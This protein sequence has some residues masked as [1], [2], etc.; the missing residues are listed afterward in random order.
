MLRRAGCWCG[1]A[2]GDR[3][4]A[5]AEWSANA[6]QVGDAVDC[7]D[8][9]DNWCKAT[10]MAV[11]EQDVRVRF[12]GWSSAADENIRK[13]SDRL[14]KPGSRSGNAARRAG[15]KKR[16]QG[17]QWALS[18]QVLEEVQARVTGVVDGTLPKE[19]QVRGCA[20][21]ACVALVLARCLPLVV[22]VVLVPLWCC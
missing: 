9:V 17:L 1:G 16:K 12:Q 7:L 8:R 5:P 6:L 18:P 14:A 22:R 10:V 11:T 2:T 21:A 13:S 4:V 19:D 20:C 3:E 15:N